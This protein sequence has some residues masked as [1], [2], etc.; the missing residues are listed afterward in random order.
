[1]LGKIERIRDYPSGS[2]L[3]GTLHHFCGWGIYMFYCSIKNIHVVVTLNSSNQK[4]FLLGLK[5]NH[6]DLLSLS[7]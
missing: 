1:M 7:D 3:P 4:V 2:L 5:G 6:V